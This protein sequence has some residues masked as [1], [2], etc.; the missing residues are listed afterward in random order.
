MAMTTKEFRRRRLDGRGWA[1]IAA[2][3][4]AV[5][6]V[7]L[8]VRSCGTD[9]TSDSGALGQS[10]T[11]PMSAKGS[12]VPQIPHRTLSPADP[13][14]LTAAPK[15]ISWQRVDGVPLPFSATDGPTR[16]QGAVT[17]GYSNSPQ[18]AV[19]AAAQIAFRLAFSPD[20]QAVVDAQTDVSDATRTQLIAA[21]AA[22]PQPDP[23]LIS[24]FASAPVAFRVSAFADNHATVY[25]AYPRT[26]GNQ[27]R[28]SRS[29][30]IWEGG[31]WRYSDQFDSQSPP[32]PDAP[33]PATFTRF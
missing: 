30:L 31:D 27:V 24:Q 4:V 21:R 6:V 10:S 14:Y 8:L 13:D 33:L 15:G 11:A 20:Y 25:L 1:I 19:L 26:P 17:G 3:V 16:I 23:A 12:L 2:L 18:G 28:F 9:P 22:G 5:V 32:L 29:A 7:T